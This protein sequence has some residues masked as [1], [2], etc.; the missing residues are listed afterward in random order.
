MTKTF[1]FEQ[2]DISYDQLHGTK[3]LKTPHVTTSK[4]TLV[5]FVTVWS[6][7]TK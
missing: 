6:N 3:W 7:K 1:H 2:S 5:L 4:K